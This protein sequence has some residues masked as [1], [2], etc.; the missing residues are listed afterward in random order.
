MASS[1]QDYLPGGGG[2]EVC[3]HQ[4]WQL[5]RAAP[6]GHNFQHVCPTPADCTE[7]LRLSLPLL[8]GVWAG[9]GR[10]EGLRRCR[11]VPIAPATH[12][13][14]PKSAFHSDM[15]VNKPQVPAGSHLNLL[16]GLKCDTAKLLCKL[17]YLLLPM[18]TVCVVWQISNCTC[19]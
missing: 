2:A 9:A 19:S 6:G 10:C 5:W 8:R 11:W 18:V 15:D 12:A 3:I 7:A 17:C 16:D 4:L 1:L 14:C 13:G